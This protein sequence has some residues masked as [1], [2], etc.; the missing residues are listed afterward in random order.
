MLFTGCANDDSE[1]VAV[2]VTGCAIA[3]SVRRLDNSTDELGQPIR[4][5]NERSLG[6]CFFC[7]GFNLSCGKKQ[8]LLWR[9]KHWLDSSISWHRRDL[10]DRGHSESWQ[11]SSGCRAQT[12]LMFLS[13]TVKTIVE[14]AHWKLFPWLFIN[15]KT[16]NKLSEAAVSEEHLWHVFKHFDSSYVSQDEG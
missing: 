10:H 3:T 9:K 5:L 7:R 6:W 8:L 16:K 2:D 15:N 4:T 12:A 11:P 13:S 1:A 14:L